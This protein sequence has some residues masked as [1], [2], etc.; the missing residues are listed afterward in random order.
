MFASGL[1]GCRFEKLQNHSDLL[2]IFSTLTIRGRT[3]MPGFMIMWQGN[4]PE[5]AHYT[6]I[7]SKPFYLFD[8]YLLHA[9]IGLFE[10][11]RKK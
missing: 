2:I 9:I 10:C 4:K 1:G 11:S 7:L 8:N 5:H 3:G 6:W